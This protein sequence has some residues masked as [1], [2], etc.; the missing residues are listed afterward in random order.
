MTFKNNPI[1][2]RKG[3]FSIR[4]FSE[5]IRELNRYDALKE[6]E[7]FYGLLSFE[8]S[9]ASFMDVVHLIASLSLI[10]HE[11]AIKFIFDNRDKISKRLLE[12]NFVEVRE[13]ILA[14]YRLNRSMGT[15]LV[16]EFKDELK[17]YLLQNIDN[18][19]LI[20][21]GLIITSISRCSEKVASEILDDDVVLNKICNSI[22]ME[23]F[24]S[25]EL[26]RIG[27]FFCSLMLGSKRLAERVAFHCKNEIVE[28]FEKRLQTASFEELGVFLSC[29]S[30]ASKVI[31]KLIAGN[32]GSKIAD[33]FAKKIDE[34]SI[35]DI[36]VLLEGISFLDE[37]LGLEVYRRFR[38]T[39]IGKLRASEIDK[40]LRFLQSMKKSN[41]YIYNDL[42]SSSTILAS[43]RSP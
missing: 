23:K 33:L 7:K 1:Y 21:H 38:N 3:Q 5:R 29:I 9:R 14:P 27:S 42:I 18:F 43:E 34:N 26:E 8:A 2:I 4:E 28:R 40:V 19:S 16:I 6:L 22:K 15:F 31:K 11:A 24:D 37:K 30:R 20:K 36:R 32:F 12:A 10:D 13:F 39:I 25:E 41:K 17:K 35:S